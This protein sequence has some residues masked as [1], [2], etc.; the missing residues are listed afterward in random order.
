M[1]LTKSKLKKIIKEEKARLMEYGGRPYDPTR[2][3]DFER[4]RDNPTGDAPMGGVQDDSG[5]DP[6]D[7]YV[8]WVEE[9]GHIA[10]SAATAASYIVE[11]PK[12]EAY[13]VMIA[14]AFG[15]MVSDISRE[16]KRQRKE[17]DAGGVLSDD[18]DYARGLKEGR[19]RIT[20][21]Q[22]KK[23]IKEELQNTLQEGWW[24]FGKKKKEAEPEVKPSISTEERDELFSEFQ[25]LWKSVQRR[26]NQ[27][28]YNRHGQPMS[29]RDPRA[30]TVGTRLCRDDYANICHGALEDY[31]ERVKEFI[32]VGKET[33]QI[34][35][36]D[37][38]V[39]DGGWGYKGTGRIEA[40][41]GSNME[42][43]EE[44]KS[45]LSMLDY[46]AERLIDKLKEKHEEWREN[47]DKHREG[48]RKAKEWE[49]QD[50]VEDY[51][52][53]ARPDFDLSFRK[54]K[55]RS[56]R[57]N[58]YAEYLQESNKSKL[59]RIIKEELKNL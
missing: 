44:L 55:R 50:W 23:L 38:D 14:D 52:S 41:R 3:G 40:G 24:P 19:M 42:G 32:R 27:M 48:M 13:K 45:K 59:K 54:T 39:L 31:S 8:A 11:D 15:L 4:Y 35:K 37:I 20:R 49:E 34:E 2:S 5:S 53:E 57:K 30:P 51:E 26:Y 58:P 1:K 18:E 12:R 56:G 47:M 43:F 21:R 36:A 6:V 17:Y 10:P 9:S 28:L 22:L 29:D 7:D 25:T 16:V 33:G 46:R